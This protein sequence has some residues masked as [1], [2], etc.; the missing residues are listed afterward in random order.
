M[1]FQQKI[2]RFTLTIG[3]GKS[4]KWKKVGVSQRKMKII[5]RS[6]P[7]NVDIYLPHHFK[8][9]SIQYQL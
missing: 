9:T 3:R 6:S 7:Q 5:K 4:P 2:H 8:N 1:I